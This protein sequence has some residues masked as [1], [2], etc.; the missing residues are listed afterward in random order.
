[1]LQGLR[2]FKFDDKPGELPSM[3][4]HL[5][6]GFE[7]GWCWT[8][9]DHYQLDKSFCV[10]VHEGNLVEVS[11]FSLLARATIAIEPT[12]RSLNRYH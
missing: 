4:P 2:I 11:T 3:I 1:M 9:S 8:D 12:T 6:L 10:S 7:Y 5:K